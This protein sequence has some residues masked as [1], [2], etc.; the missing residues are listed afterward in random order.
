MTFTSDAAAGDQSGAMTVNRIGLFGVIAALALTEPAPDASASGRPIHLTGD[1]T[2]SSR[3]AELRDQGV[4]FARCDQ[5]VI[6]ETG[7][8]LLIEF[9]SETGGK[10]F[11]YTVEHVFDSPIVGTAKVTDLQIRAGEA[12]DAR[13]KCTIYESDTLISTVTCIAT[14]QGRIYVANFETDASRF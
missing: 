10:A 9:S 8:A 12:V 2:Y 14:W 11:T 13:G 5:V 6:T 4:A 1:C 3:Y 7:M